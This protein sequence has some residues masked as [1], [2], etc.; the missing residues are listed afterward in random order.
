MS[1]EKYSLKYNPYSKTYQNLSTRYNNLRI[2]K[3]ELGSSINWLK[4]KNKFDL[5]NNVQLLNE[6]V[7]RA[8]RQ[9]ELIQLKNIEVTNEF[10]SKKKKASSKLLYSGTKKQLLKECEDL[11]EEVN[12]VRKIGKKTNEEYKRLK[13]KLA[14]SENDLK[15]YNSLNK[16]MCL[17]RYEIVSVDVERIENE[18]SDVFVKK[19]NLDKDLLP[20]I[21]RLS[22]IDRE[23]KDVKSII[24]RAENYAGKL[25]VESSPK[26]RSFVHKACERELGDGRPQRIIN[27][28]KGYLEM[29][30]REM[31]KLEIRAERISKRGTLNINTIIIDGNNMCY[32]SGEF[33]IGLKALKPVVSELKEKFEIIVVFDPEISFLLKRNY[34]RIKGSFGKGVK[35]HIVASRE[36]ADETIVNMASNRS[37]IYIISNDRFVEYFDKEVVAGERIICHEIVK[38]KVLIND[39]GIDIVW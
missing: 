19:S 15:Y 8:Q 6:K 39:L 12:K 11:K 24:N 18:K 5:E 20:T 33:F 1:I 26:N 36:K 10:N 27:K 32:E 37:D 21:N 22:D 25:D 38:N 2:E 7:N 17:R 13:N 31:K 4:N 3:E 34:K 30:E 29:L 9:I 28:N 14:V 35:V 16:E 23:I